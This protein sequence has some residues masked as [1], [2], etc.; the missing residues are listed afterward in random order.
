MR[1]IS[2][3]LA[4]LVIIGAASQAFGQQV[5]LAAG[6]WAPFTGKDLPGQGFN[7]ELV[8]AAFKAVGI[9]A[10]YNWYGDAWLRCENETQAGTVFGTFPYT[11]TP[12]R[13]KI[14]D[15]SDGVYT[16][17]SYI[18][19]VEGRG[20]DVTWTSLKDFAGHSFIGIPGYD[21]VPR[22]Q[23]AGLKMETA[24][25][26]E[27]GFRMLQSGRA[28]YLIED[29]MVAAPAIK[30]AFGPDASKVKMVTKPWHEAIYRI[31]VSRTYPNAA[32]LLKKFNQGL[33]IIKKN[34]TY[35]AIL[36]KYG[37]NG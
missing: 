21:Y 17:R 19:Y 1:K 18:Y 10:Q 8:T 30:A 32:D 14:Y 2:I 7:T 24:T 27:Q 4:I 22:I 36:A 11:Q 20:K 12:E 13:S 29:E 25:T 9:T 23:E 31:M 3:L 35:K 5:T 33:D 16:S 6:E 26:T 34:G 28:E 15:F 37:L